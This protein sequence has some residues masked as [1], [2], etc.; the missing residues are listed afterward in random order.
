MGTWSG[1]RLIA[2]VERLGARGLGYDELHREL[3]ARIRQVIPVDATC[4]HGLDPDT[5]L[6][7]TANPVELLD[8]GIL[9]P[10]TEHVAAGSVIASEYLRPDVNTLTSLAG[11]RTPAAILGESTRGR[12]ERS[13]RYND[14]LAPVGVPYELRVA[15]VTRGRTWG[16]VIMH[17]REDAGDFRP[18]EAR[19]MAR[20]SRPIA[21]AMR[22][23]VAFDAGRRAA[24]DGAPGMVVLGATNDIEMI[25]PPT[26]ALFEAMLPRGGAT[27]V[28]APVLSLAADARHAGLAGRAARPLHVPTTMGVV[29]LHAS[30]PQGPAVGRVA[31]VIQPARTEHTTRLRLEAF[32]LT[33][34][35]RE[36]AELVA[37]GFDTEA[38]A[39]RLVISPWT[40][41]DH[42][43]SIFE[44][45]GTRSRS[46][47]RASIFFHDH[48]P[49]I[50]ARAPLDS[51]GQ[52]TPVVPQPRHPT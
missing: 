52:L 2:D 27:G 22:A 30:L 11:R 19:L 43:K 29:T 31:I 7:T 40:V 49:A 15:L 44:R 1:Q 33:A 46:E 18:D 42:L 14:Y 10:E 35:E 37:A 45:T 13:A 9:V 17:R 48:L 6:I 38:I 26:S 47:L 8:T 4:W 12:P 25:T 34:R 16:A 36:V 5:L 51:R 23:S 28:P 50:M 39:T 24:V 20:L 32:G 41:Q 21:E 3:S